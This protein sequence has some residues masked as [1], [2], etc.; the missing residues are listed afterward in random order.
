MY[1]FGGNSPEEIAAILNIS[2]DEVLLVLEDSEEDE[3]E[4]DNW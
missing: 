4:E 2:V 1:N 3:E